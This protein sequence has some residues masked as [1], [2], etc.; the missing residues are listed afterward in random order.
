[1]P[2]HVI[3]PVVAEKVRLSR[4][5][6]A[7]LSALH[8]GR[9]SNAELSLIALKYTSRVSDCRAAGHDIR[10]VESDRATGRFIYAL[11]VDGKEVGT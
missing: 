5:S 3:T 11:F 9:V 7:I 4:Q 6:A 2:A 8:L 10:V 1:M